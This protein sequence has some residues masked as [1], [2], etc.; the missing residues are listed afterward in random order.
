MDRRAIDPAATQFFDLRGALMQK[1]EPGKESY[2]G[3]VPFW[4][5]IAY[6]FGALSGNFM[7]NVPWAFIGP[8]YNV[9]LKLDPVLIGI[10]TAIPRIFDAISDPWVGN[11]SDNTR[12]RFGRRI[13]YMFSGALLS[14]AVLPLMWMPP[15]QSTW[16]LFSFLAVTASMFA[17]S[18][19]LYIIPY[20]ALGF[21]LT[22]DY[23]ERTRLL[24][25]PNYIGLLGSFVIM[26]VPNM[27][28]RWT[29]DPDL[30]GKAHVLFPSEL[31]AAR[32]I[33]V[34]VGILIIVFGWI[35]VFFLKEPQA[36]QKQNPI[37]ILDALKYT[38]QNR[39]YLMLL[40][41]S[42]I[43]QG[44]LSTVGVFGFYVNTYL[45]FG[46]D[47]SMGTEIGAVGGN[48]YTVS[49][50]IGVFMLAKIA[51][52]IGKKVAMHCGLLIAAVGSAS[53][54]WTLSSER[55]SFLGLPEYT[56][57]PLIAPF[58]I[59]LGLQGCWMLFVSMTG[60]VCDE[61]EL[62]TGLRRE[63]MY[64]AITG[65]SQ[66]ISLAFAGLFGGLILKYSGFDAAA[67]ETSGVAPEVLDNMKTFFV[68]GQTGVF[69]LAFIMI[70]F[71][72]IT[73]KR[74]LETRRILDERR[75]AQ[76]G[77]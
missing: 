63:G 11:L 51:T 68:L 32:W 76:N 10:A 33:S 34:G 25:W 28:Y 75:K 67:A 36:A 35:P 30:P 43:V 18:Y 62:R 27:L 26:W 7:L 13:P 60:D 16:M 20:S 5:K 37:K 74:A 58:I 50:Y 45:V 39:A 9:A 31:A 72:P 59:G 2:R 61:D 55:F 54:G 14:A 40:I 49:A 53:Y 29:A 52:S 77:L 21:E 44:G 8:I 1:L 70:S 17:V 42:L 73:K 41:T 23:N 46:G 24:A 15:S 65:F 64:S 47:K 19:T 12:S 66:K 57:L 4:R 71:F 69:L 48:L 38:L 56:Y 22:S 6:G 3:K